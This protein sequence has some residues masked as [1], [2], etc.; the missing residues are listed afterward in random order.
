[1]VSVK[2]RNVPTQAELVELHEN[3]LTAISYLRGRK[4]TEAL[5]VLNGVSEAIAVVRTTRKKFDGR[6]N[7]VRGVSKENRPG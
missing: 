5:E 2:I 1:M 4:V 6:S 7:K 3:V